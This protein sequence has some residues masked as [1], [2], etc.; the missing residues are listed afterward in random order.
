MQRERY[1]FGVGHF[2]RVRGRRTTRHRVVVGVVCAL[3]VALCGV[4]SARAATPPPGAETIFVPLNDR[5]AIFS[6]V[7]SLERPVKSGLAHIGQILDQE[8]YRVARYGPGD[9]ARGSAANFLSLARKPPAVLVIATADSTVGGYQLAIEIDG[10]RRATEASYRSLIRR[11]G[12]HGWFGD[13]GSAVTIT[14]AGLRHFFARGPKFDK[15]LVVNLAC[16]STLTSRDFGA[17]DYVGFAPNK[18]AC[19]LIPA[20]DTS[21]HDAQLL[22]DRLAGRSGV[23]NRSLVW[24]YHLGGFGGGQDHPALSLFSLSD[25]YFA[26]ALSPAVTAASVEGEN[27][28]LVSGGDYPGSVQF[29]AL[30]QPGHPDGVV[31]VSGCGASIASAKWLDPSTLDFTV[32]LPDGAS[33][34]KMTF[35]V[36]HAAAKAYYGSGSAA[37]NDDLD[38]NEAPS[39]DSGEAPNRTDYSWQVSCDPDVYPVK[40][41]YSG[42]FTDTYHN[43]QNNNPGAGPFDYDSTYTWTETQFSQA[44]F[45]GSAAQITPGSG[46]VNVSGS[47]TASSGATCTA[48]PASSTPNAGIEFGQESV[49]GSTTTR[50]LG[51]Y[52]SLPQ[53]VM[54]G[55]AICESRNGQ[56]YS[57]LHPAEDIYTPADGPS[58]F[59]NASL[60][61]VTVNLAQLETGP[62]VTSFPV[63]YTA[64]DQDGTGGVDHVVVSATETVSLATS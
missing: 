56:P 36:P 18:A 46:T 28:G 40:I 31:R 62:V 6:T 59:T 51:V 20:L 54:S 63:D 34:G 47:S 41:V 9:A 43:P 11:Y 55:A 33:N 37:P 49:I 57:N 3:A 24:A 50:T 12:S 64:D 30:M 25:D 15:E 7:G 27:R 52:A 4:S 16:H 38:G 26:V 14:Q 29:D 13:T 8:G 35:T 5:A 45:H 58:A 32:H 22:F 19:D 17:L 21:I 61:M 2:G 53:V 48:G 10:N 23:Q 39:T 44:A 60:G 1:D 42:T